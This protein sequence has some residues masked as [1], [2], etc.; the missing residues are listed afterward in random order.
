M[1]G[2]TEEMDKR[3]E[4]HL[5]SPDLSDRNISEHS[6]GQLDS[7]GNMETFC[8]INGQNDH[9]EMEEDDFKRELDIKLLEDDIDKGQP[10]GEDNDNEYTRE[11]GNSN[12]TGQNE[13]DDDIGDATHLIGELDLKEQSVTSDQDN[14]SNPKERGNSN[15]QNITEENQSDMDDSYDK[16]SWEEE[17]INGQDEICTNDKEYLLKEEN[18]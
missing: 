6:K 4:G 11:Q 5:A 17:D 2:V 15:G 1:K 16:Y 7:G 18:N 14:I 13:T 12:S 10:E 9:L 8:D 3:S